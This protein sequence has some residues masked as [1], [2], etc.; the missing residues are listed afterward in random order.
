MHDK[1]KRGSRECQESAVFRPAVQA[2]TG[3]PVKSSVRSKFL[4][5]CAAVH[6]GHDL[7]LNEATAMGDFTV[8]VRVST[9]D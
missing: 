1:Y 8:F 6:C 5:F 9:R 2:V 4:K 3:L 7:Q